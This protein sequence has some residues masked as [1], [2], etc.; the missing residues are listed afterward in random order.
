MFFH[1][2]Y[3][4]LYC[5]YVILYYIISCDGNIIMIADCSYLAG[6]VCVI[7]EIHVML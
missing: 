2:I 6:K 1:I 3:T 5:V 4:Y 7:V